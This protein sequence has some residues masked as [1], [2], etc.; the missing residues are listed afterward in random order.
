MKRGIAIRT[1]ELREV[2][3]VS[4]DISA[5]TNKP[6]FTV[7]DSDGVFATDTVFPYTQDGLSSI[8]QLIAEEVTRMNN[9]FDVYHD[10]YVELRRIEDQ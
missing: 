1:M 4:Q 3:I 8:L 7:S 6:Y 5:I 9:L 2:E 10:K